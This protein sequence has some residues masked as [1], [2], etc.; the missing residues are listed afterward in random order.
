MNIFMTMGNYYSNT[1]PPITKSQFLS[2]FFVIMHDLSTAMDTLENA[3]PLIKSGDLKLSLKLSQPTETNYHFLA[4]ASS[5]SLLTMD[6]NA[7]CAVSYR[8]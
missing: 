6:G 4:F 5:P 1:G 2:D 7:V 8:T 3:L